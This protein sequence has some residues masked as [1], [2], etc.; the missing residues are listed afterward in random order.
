MPEK[1]TEAEWKS[2][3]SKKPDHEGSGGYGKEFRFYSE[4]DG[5]SLKGMV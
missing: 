4:Y 3:I 5:M 2:E 1:D